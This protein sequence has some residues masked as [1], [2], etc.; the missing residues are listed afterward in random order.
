[1]QK[2]RRIDKHPQIMSTKDP[3]TP[4]KYL[5]PLE[6]FVTKFKIRQ[7]PI[8]PIKALPQSCKKKIPR[9]IEFTQL[10]SVIPLNFIKNSVH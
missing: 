7:H 8:I 2:I 9:N 4:K 3:S 6:F 1:M 5:N 10:F